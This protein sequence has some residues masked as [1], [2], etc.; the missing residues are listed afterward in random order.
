M[1]VTVT[2]A[3][4]IVATQQLAEAV[5]TAQLRYIRNTQYSSYRRPYPLSSVCLPFFIAAMPTANGRV[6]KPAAWDRRYMYCAS[7][8]VACIVAHCFLAAIVS[9]STCA[10]YPPV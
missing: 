7:P 2:T 5:S 1:F 10:I 8:S 3:T 6:V 4:T 9:P